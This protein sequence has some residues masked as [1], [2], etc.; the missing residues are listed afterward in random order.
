MDSDPM[1]LKVSF[2]PPLYQQRRIWVLDILRRERITEVVDIGC[3]HGELLAALCQPA[4]WL[5]PRSHWRKGLSLQDADNGLTS[6]FD[7]VLLDDSETPD[8][9]PVRIAGLDI[10]TRAL[11]SAA[12]LTSPSAN[13]LYTRWESLEVSLWHGSL[14]S[15]NPTFVD[16]E[17]IVATEVIEHLTDDLVARFAP[18]I[19]GVYHPRIFLMTTPS[20]TFN[21]RFSPPG[22]SD[23]SGYVDPTGRTDRV[24][25][26]SDHK[27]EWTP[28]EF[29][30][31][32]TTVGKEWGYTAEVGSIG[33]ALEE[34]PWGRDSQL[35][36]A[37]QTAT[38]RR[39]DDSNSR[40]KRER[41][42]RVMY[43]EMAKKQPHQLVIT[44]HFSPHPH[45]GRPRDPEEIR[46]AVLCTFEEWGDAVLRVED[47][48]FSKDIAVM[49]G[50]SIDLLTEIVERETRLYLQR[51]P[52][53]RK[54]NWT[55]EIKGGVQRRRDDWSTARRSRCEVEED[56][57]TKLSESSSQ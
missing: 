39:M 24:F 8:L 7:S 14:D 41:R 29:A 32:C 21:A 26:N 49:C 15:I 43:D 13:T 17:C 5:G 23:P 33:T 35:G 4:P 22:T 30:I 27:F 52:G 28:E 37:S 2:F 12:E 38:F 25:R 45:A 11:Q 20:Y 51:I 9:H 42:T 31:W 48:W 44:H 54:E 10:S 56:P 19:L 46:A 50:G 55:V 1:E 53:Q 34:D 36:G 18:V 47:L 57:I 3:G 16:V 6:L 40:R